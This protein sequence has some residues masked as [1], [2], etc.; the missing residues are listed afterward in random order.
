[1]E[2]IQLQDAR[3]DVTWEE[4]KRSECEVA[5][6]ANVVD[7]VRFGRYTSVYA[8]KPFGDDRDEGQRAERLEASFV[9][10]LRV[11]MLALYL[12]CVL[13]TRAATF[14]TTTEEEEGVWVPDFE[15]PEVE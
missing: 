13:F 7:R 3:D 2:S 8:K 15:S 10:T 4:P 14:T 6:L 5:H 9:H 11:F 1:M 12:E